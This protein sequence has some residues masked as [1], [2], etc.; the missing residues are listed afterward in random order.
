MSPGPLRRLTGT[1]GLVALAPTALMLAMDR[2]TP[3]DAALR[4]AATLL[5]A[6]LIGRVADW[7]VSAIARGLELPDDAGDELE[8]APPRRRR[9]DAPAA[10][11]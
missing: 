1:L 9:D 7:W 4:A 5:A 2:I 8:D 11:G 10:A 6:M 3:L